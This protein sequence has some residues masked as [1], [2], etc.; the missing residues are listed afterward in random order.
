MPKKAIRKIAGAISAAISDAETARSSAHDPTFHRAL[1]EDRRGTLS[2]Y[3]TVQDALRDRAAAEKSSAKSAA[4]G[5]TKDKNDTSSAK[6]AAKNEK[7]PAKSQAAK[8]RR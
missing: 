3:Q 7:R 2:R 6:A 1:Q 8:K 4:R 5:A